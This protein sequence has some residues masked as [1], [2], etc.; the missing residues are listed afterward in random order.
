MSAASRLRTP[1][2]HLGA[3]YGIV[4]SAFVS[5]AICSLCS[6]SSAGATTFVAEMMVG[7][8]LVLYLIIARRRADDDR[9][10]FLRLRPAGAAGL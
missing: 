7:V 1:N 8:P 9:R 4:A 10:G 6:S 3:Y 5:L 2:P